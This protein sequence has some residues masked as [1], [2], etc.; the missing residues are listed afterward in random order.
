MTSIVDP[1]VALLAALSSTLEKDYVDTVPSPWRGSPFE[2]IQTRPSRQKG[3]IGEALVAGWAAAKGFDVARTGDSDADRL[4]AGMRI[5]IKYSNLW[6][7][8]GSYKFQQIRDQRYEYC[9]CL[10]LSPFEAHAWFIPKP[11]LM[12]ELKQG[13]SPQHGGQEG[14]DTRWLSFLAEH[15]P[16]WLEPYGGTLTQVATLIANCATI[17]V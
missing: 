15:P 6:S 8:I 5:E 7:D 1:E 11:V 10:G 13:L 2:W 12:G 4:I 17:D 9:F 14:H 16:A 3:A